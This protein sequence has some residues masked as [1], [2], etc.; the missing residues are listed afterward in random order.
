MDKKTAI[1]LMQ[2]YLRA[3]EP[4][5]LAAKVIGGLPD[6]E[7]QKRLRRPLGEVGQSIYVELMRPIIREYPE[8]DQD[9]VP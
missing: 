6:E 3:C 8:L 1:D 9:R 7:E 2:L 4:L 5:N